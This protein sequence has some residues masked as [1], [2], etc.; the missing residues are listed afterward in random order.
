MKKKMQVFLLLC[1][2]VLAA[3]TLAPTK[4]INPPVPPGPG[5][6]IFECPTRQTAFDY[7][8]ARF[9]GTYCLITCYY[10]DGTYGN[11]LRPA[12]VGVCEATDTG[13]IYH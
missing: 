7:S 8:A 3:A 2:V 12:P 9:L 1:S 13:A 10:E 6:Y 11:I 5:P 4:P